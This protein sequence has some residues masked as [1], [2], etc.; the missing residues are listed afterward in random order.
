MIVSNAP[1]ILLNGLQKLRLTESLVNTSPRALIFF[2]IFPFCG[3]TDTP[4]FGLLVTSPLGFRA[5]VGSSLF[6]LGGGVRVSH[7][8]PGL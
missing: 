3:A 1:C 6:A 4:C 5:R 7:S 2:L 8:L